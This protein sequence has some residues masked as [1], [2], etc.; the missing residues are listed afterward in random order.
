MSAAGAANQGQ[1][2]GLDGVVERSGVVRLRLLQNI[3]VDNG[4]ITKQPDY[5]NV[6]QTS[7]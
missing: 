7:S 4:F 6:R 1:G 5:P 2:D 3:V